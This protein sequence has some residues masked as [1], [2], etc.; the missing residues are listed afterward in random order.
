MGNVF[1]EEFAM[2]LFIE[3]FVSILLTSLLFWI[4]VVPV[5]QK[6]TVRLSTRIVEGL[7]IP[8]CHEL[9]QWSLKR[10][11]AMSA[12][13][14][15]QIPKMPKMRSYVLASNI[16]FVMVLLVMVVATS[17]FSRMSGKAIFYVLLEVFAIYLLVAIGQIYFI[18]R[19]AMKYAPITF[20]SLYKVAVTRLAQECLDRN[21]RLVDQPPALSPS[22]GVCAP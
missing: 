16:M 12:N 8:P 4:M 13:M 5:A 15:E 18:K 22:A 17:A 2:S 21:I 20:E 1:N 10:L 11:E 3:M 6:H 19:V 7:R 14:A 9:L